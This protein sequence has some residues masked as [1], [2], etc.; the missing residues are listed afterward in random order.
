MS[1]EQHVFVRTP[2]T[3]MGLN[4]KRPYR[5]PFDWIVVAEVFLAIYSLAG[6]VLALSLGNWGPTFFLG[7]CAVGFGYVAFLSLRELIS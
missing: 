1:G 3:G 4:G 5:L 2:K 6:L 7:M